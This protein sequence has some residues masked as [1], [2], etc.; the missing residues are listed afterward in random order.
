MSDKAILRE[1]LDAI[2]N[3]C[4]SGE[5]EIV[6]KAEGF[7]LYKRGSAWGV[8]HNGKRYRLKTLGLDEAFQRKL[9]VQF[10]RR[11]SREQSLEDFYREVEI[12]LDGPEPKP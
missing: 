7:E 3:R 11:S 2:I 5:L 10:P 4:Q 6:L 8:R 12:D 1:R 9:S